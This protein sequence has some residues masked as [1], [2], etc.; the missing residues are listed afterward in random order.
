MK[1]N[2]Q[3]LSQQL[4]PVD[5]PVSAAVT[6]KKL[7]YD[8]TVNHIREASN[9]FPPHLQRHWPVQKLHHI[10][11]FT[12]WRNILQRPHPP[13]RHQNVHCNND[14]TKTC[15]GHQVL[16]E[17]KSFHTLLTSADSRGSTSDKYLPT[18]SWRLQGHNSN[19]LVLVEWRIK[20][21][22]NIA[23]K[24]ISVIGFW[25][26]KTEHRHTC[27]KSFTHECDWEVGIRCRIWMIFLQWT[28]KFA[29]WS[30]ASG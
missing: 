12:I 6:I 24:Q 27:N 28:T 8:L 10:K 3:Y 14:D 1:S 2:T 29:N 30:A 18:N 25:Q 20:V 11:N 16:I 5:Q 4:P 26:R 13:R 7:N 17:W 21:N 9:L 19:Q 15:N 23:L 22:H